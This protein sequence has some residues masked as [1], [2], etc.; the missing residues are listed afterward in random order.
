[1][2]MTDGFERCNNKNNKTE[3]TYDWQIKKVYG[4]G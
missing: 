4:K 1:M 3:G 2:R